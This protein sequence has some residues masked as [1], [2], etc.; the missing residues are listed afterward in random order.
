MPARLEIRG[1]ASMQAMVS[2]SS[3]STVHPLRVDM[4]ADG[5]NRSFRIRNRDTDTD[6]QVIDPETGL[7]GV[8]HVGIRDGSIAAVSELVLRKSQDFQ[9]EFLA[10]VLLFSL[11]VL[12]FSLLLVLVFVLGREQAGWNEG[13]RG[14]T[15][16]VARSRVVGGGRAWP[17]ERGADLQPAIDRALV[18]IQV[19]GAVVGIVAV[20]IGAHASANAIVRL[21]ITSRVTPITS[22]PARSASCQPWSVSR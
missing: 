2:L 13:L 5:L 17:A 22:N 10:S 15:G 16:L 7:D 1:A 20:A 12:N 9:T 8:R 21:G 6:Y 14:E 3:H 4:V 11:T 18:G 19:V